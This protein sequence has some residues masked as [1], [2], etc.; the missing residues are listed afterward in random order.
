MSTL[1][2]TA[3]PVARRRSYGRYVGGKTLGALGSL[4]FVLV[5]NFF[6]FRVLPG[7]PARTLGR[8]RFR[9]EEQLEA[10]KASYGLDQPLIQ[11][12]FTFLKNTAQ[13]DLGI[14]YRYRVPVTDLILDRMWPTIL[15]VGSSTILATLIGVYAGMISAWNRG[16]ALDRA[17]TGTTLTLYS[18]PEWWLGLLLIAGLAVGVGPIPGIFPTGGL[19]SVDVDPS[20][21]AGVMDTAWHLVLPVVTLTLAYLADYSLVMRSSLLDELGEDY[22]VTARAKGLRDIDVRRH[23]A[24]RNAL[25]PTTTIIALN[26]GFVVSGAITIETV[27]SIPGLG[28]L[29]TE[30]LTIPDYWVLQG[31]FLV[32][33]GGGHLRQPR[34]QPALRRARPAGAHMTDLTTRQLS[35]QRRR[36]SLRRTWKEFRG[37]RSGLVGLVILSFFVLVA[38]FAPL[39]SSAES[40]EI[41]KATGGVLES[42]SGSYLLGTDDAGRSVL[43]LLIWGARISLFVGLVATVI[44]MV[45]GTLVG[46]ASGFFEGWPARILFRVTEWF[47]VIPYLPLAI[48]LATVLGRSLITIVTVIGVLGWSSTAL[49]IR[50]QTLSVKERPY[51]ER[52]RV[53]GAGRWHQMTRHV[54]P[55]LMPMIF[56]NTTLTVAVAI[57]AETTLSFL[58]LGDPTRVSWG[59]MLDDAFSVGAMTTGAWWFIIPPGVCVVLVVLAFTLVGSALEEIFNPRLRK[60]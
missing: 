8:G 53:L 55:N 18:M 20:S 46:L 24:V 30:A 36:Q 32:A 54:L 26:I 48:V 45:I 38:L 57:L 13:G 5:V 27:F 40:I 12:F 2:G 6:L 44:S 17:W 52:A 15:L 9:T 7:D 11:Q 33:S 35:R 1:V 3:P 28:L 47:L 29:S 58:G 23:H 10:F 37:H 4:L 50:S 34:G 43:S 59:S 19:H 14:S 22:L 31:T 60:R 51:L 41:T 42:P 39:I 16:R 49:L 21:F 56:A 25:L